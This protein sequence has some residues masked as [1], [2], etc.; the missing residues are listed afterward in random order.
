MAAAAGDHDTL[1]WSLANQAR[2]ALASVDPVLQLK[3]SF[4]AVGIHVV[5]NGRTAQRYGF[6]EDFLNG[7]V[8]PGQFLASERSGSA[9]GPDARPEQRFVGVD[10][11]HAAQ[12][13]LI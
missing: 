12:Q 8:K 7:S 13:F 1:N 5:R 9:P 6:F 4:L 3:E 10:V 11:A 2:F